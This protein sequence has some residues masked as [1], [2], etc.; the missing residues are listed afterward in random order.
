[1]KT[2]FSIKDAADFLKNGS[3]VAIGNYDGFHLGH[4]SILRELIA[5]AKVQHLKSTILTF[6]PH[7]V[8]VFSPKVAPLLINTTAQ[9]I[10]LA[11]SLGIDCLVIQ[12][13][14]LKFA[15][16]LPDDFFTQ[17]LIKKLHA[18][19]IS[20]GYD[21]T[22]GKDRSGTTDHLE[23]LGAQHSVTVKIIDAKYYKKSTLVSSTIVRK[24]IQDG[25]LQLA[26]Q[27][28]TRP[29]FVD[30]VVVHGH[31][32]GQKL[33]I[34]T[35]NLQTDNE[36]IP[37]DGV[38]ATLVQIKQK[39]Y[40]SVTNIGYN[41]T[42]DNENRTIETHIF[43]F[44]DNIYDKNLRLFFIKKIRHEKRFDSPQSL[45]KQIHKDVAKA[46]TVLSSHLAKFE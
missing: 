42:F 23:L 5:Q 41:P 37:Q 1:M 40:Q 36:L 28:L 31:Q 32:R 43:D 46:K 18:R 25:Q 20:V 29:F 44:D 19:Y 39:V 26:N 2:F 7:P 10:E 14:D 8:K 30:G 11:R 24:L 15:R 6:D 21:F 38:Y 35:A 34:Q 27:L 12:K 9:K 13:F 22:F 3:A 45:V 4:R 16:I 33:G 17:L